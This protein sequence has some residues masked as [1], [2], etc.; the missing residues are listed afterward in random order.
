[1]AYGTPLGTA[2]NGA[3]YNQVVAGRDYYYQQEWSNETGGCQQRK[4]LPPAVSKISPVT[5]PETGGTSVKIM[6]L[7]FKAPDVTAVEFGEKA[8]VKFKVASATSLTAVSPAS[9]P[10]SVDITLTNSAGQSVAVS[11]DRFT[12][13]PP[14]TVSSVTPN[15]GPAAGGTSVTV[16]G[17]NFLVGKTTFKFGTAKATSVNCTSTTECTMLAPAHAA[18]TV[19]VIATVNKLNSPVV[20]GDKYT[21]S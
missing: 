15:T 21:Y 8:A 6:G 9:A 11:A 2:P 10:G 17:L 3:L 12:F 18:G 7:N 20:T 1:M 16:T 4:S 19:D 14:P 5:G 13:T